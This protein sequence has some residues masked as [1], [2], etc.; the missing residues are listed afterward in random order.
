MM[1]SDNLQSGDLLFT[2]IPNPVFRHVAAA[3]GSP[4][5]HVGIAFRDPDG[6]WLVA[7]GAVPL[8]RFTPLQ[9]FIERSEDGWCVVKRLRGGLDVAQ[10]T[11]LRQA[12]TARMGRLYHTGFRYDTPHRQF[13]SQLAHDAYLDA[14]GVTLG[15][16]ESFGDLLQRQPH[17]A[18]GFWRLWFFGRIP[19]SRRTVTPASLLDSPALHTVWQPAAPAP[20]RPSLRRRL[21]ALLAGLSLALAWPA[22]AEGAGSAA[23]SEGSV[24]S[25]A[26]PVSLA[27]A[28]SALVLQG[29]TR[30]TLVSVQ[31]S[32][33]GTVWLLER[34]VDGARFVVR[35]TAGG[36]RAAS[37][38]VGAVLA[39]SA[40]STGW[41]LCA[42][43]E[44]MAFVPNADGARLMANERITP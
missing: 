44:A 9:R 20:T 31:A 42:N 26:V 35:F 13:C 30:L 7:E 2:R 14:L 1:H 34:A 25:A 43:G 12:C 29:S 24:L 11:A 4:T 8:S 33:E 38:M 28:G 37:T 27:L 40:L 17:A 16:V 32:A 36:L 5:S 6:S 41:L 22:H 15:R 3:T 18:L 10:V 39:A 21:A 19:W 23:S